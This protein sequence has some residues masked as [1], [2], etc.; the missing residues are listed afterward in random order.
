MSWLYL[1]L[2][3]AVVASPSVE[4]V[5]SQWGT[6][7]FLFSNPQGIFLDAKSGEI[8]VADP[9]THS[10]FIFN[11]KG[12]PVYHFVHM[13]PGTDRQGEP[14]DIAVDKDGLMYVVDIQA[15][16]VDVLN[17]R[18]VSVN[19]IEIKEI[20]EFEDKQVV[21]VRVSI[22]PERAIYVAIDGDDASILVF[23]S[24]L[25]YVKKIGR[26]GTEPGEFQ[27]IT[28]LWVDNRGWAYVTDLQAFFSVQVFNEEGDFVFGFGKHREGWENFSFPS[29][30]LKTAD[31]TIW[32]VD[33]LRQVVKGFDE[34]G[35]FLTYFGGKGTRPGEMLFPSDI[36]GDGGDRLVVLERVGRRFQM[37]YVKGEKGGVVYE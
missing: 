10:I 33:A 31:G 30:I 14:V 34:K 36:G 15:D 32:V 27:H 9:G 19:R 26:K 11:E 37:F 22:G 8:Y 20:E 21:P 23:D 12:I 4:V 35:N 1:A 18:G 28:G 25:K 7:D 6:R 13:L 16:Y 24:T 3:S 5:Y 29:G 2:A 17:P